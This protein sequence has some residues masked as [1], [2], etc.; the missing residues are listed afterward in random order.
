M[1]E[2]C[3]SRCFG[4]PFPEEP[5]FGTDAGSTDVDYPESGFDR[6]EKR[7]SIDRQIRGP[8][9]AV[10]LAA[11]PLVSYFGFREAQRRKLFARVD[12]TQVQLAVATQNI[13]ELRSELSKER[14]NVEKLDSLRKE[15]IALLDQID[16][17]SFLTWDEL[18]E[19][20]ALK[21][22]LH[23]ESSPSSG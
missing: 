19:L 17:N 12:H 20:E 16:R 21:A 6:I 7:Y 5:D 22:E 2:P 1:D 13:N 9:I 15:T 3:I 11:I 14:R 8:L 10:L 4:F 18:K 23:S